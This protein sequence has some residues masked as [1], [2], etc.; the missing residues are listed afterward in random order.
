[1]LTSNLLSV[2]RSVTGG[3]FLVLSTENMADLSIQRLGGR[4]TAQH[5][6]DSQTLIILILF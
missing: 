1:V 4:A 3:L 5:G 6:N 2:V